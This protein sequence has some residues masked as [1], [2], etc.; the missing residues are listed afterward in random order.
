MIYKEN[1]VQLRQSAQGKLTL[2]TFDYCS[3]VRFDHM[4]LHLFYFFYMTFL[5][6]TVKNVFFYKLL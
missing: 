4:N 5:R 6:Q 1:N 2:Y 3:K